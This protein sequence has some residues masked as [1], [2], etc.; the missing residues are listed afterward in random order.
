MWLPDALAGVTEP[1]WR[2][3]F[4]FG[5]DD[6]ERFIAAGFHPEEVAIVLGRFRP[7]EI[8]ARL[9]ERGW[10][11]HDGLLARGKD[12]SVDTATALGRLALSSLD[13]VA[14]VHRRLVAASSTALV[15]AALA[16]ADPLDDPD[17]DAAARAL[18]RVTAAVILPAELVRPASGVLTVP[19]ARERAVTVGVGVDDRGP[20]ERLLR[21]ALVYHDPA[22]A[23]RE[24]AI[25]DAFAV[26]DVPT[27]PHRRFGELIVGVEARVVA[28]RVV[29]LEGRIAD[30]ELPGLWR[31]LL[32]S[33]DLA[34]LVRQR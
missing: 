18:G 29:L 34:V 7:A 14:V 24:I 8:R 22:Q 12:G 20:S 23:T 4:G 16:P 1:R 25:G 11:R 27:R 15:E 2:R 9:R 5:I 3:T 21:I 31:G 6:V 32:E 30:E 26:A 19:L 13:R 28:E 33:G 17:I 10:R